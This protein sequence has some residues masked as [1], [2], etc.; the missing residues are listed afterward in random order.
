MISQGIPPELRPDLPCV[1]S[2][3]A[4]MIMAA[5][6]SSTG[7]GGVY[8]TQAPN[9]IWQPRTGKLSEAQVQHGAPAWQSREGRPGWYEVDEGRLRIP[10]GE[11]KG[12]TEKGLVQ[13]RE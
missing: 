7:H 3:L 2:L 10:K 13:Q 6:N 8:F 4:M 5:A 9:G 1:P 12:V 11:G